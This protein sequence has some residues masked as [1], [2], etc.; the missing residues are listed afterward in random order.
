MSR[1]IEATVKRKQM[2]ADRKDVIVYFAGGI[3]A[4]MTKSA[5]KKCPVGEVVRIEYGA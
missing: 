2:T 4:I 5:A 3:T 1:I